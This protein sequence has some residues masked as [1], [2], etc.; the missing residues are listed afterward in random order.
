MYV[1]MYVF[2]SFVSQST[3]GEL[4]S[5]WQAEFARGAQ[6]QPVRGLHAR[7]R[8]DG[9]QPGDRLLQLRALLRA[10]LQVLRVRCG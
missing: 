7:G 6:Q 4:I 5:Q 2:E 9:H 8:G 1:C 10:I 3:V